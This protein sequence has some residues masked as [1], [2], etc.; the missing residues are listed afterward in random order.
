MIDR[1]IPGE[2]KRTGTEDVLLNQAKC[3]SGPAVQHHVSHSG[4]LGSPQAKEKVCL[5]HKQLFLN[6]LFWDS[7]LPHTLE[8]AYN[9]C[10]A[11]PLMEFVQLPF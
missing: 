11:K 7:I 1:N 4:P 3:S 9:H 6:N 8:Q 5:A 10:N 2:K